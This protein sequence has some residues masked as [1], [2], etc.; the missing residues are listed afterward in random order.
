M[1]RKN[2]AT[3]EEKGYEEGYE[4]KWRK[5]REMEGCVERGYEEKI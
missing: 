2:E 4:E 3:Q 1:S 5:M